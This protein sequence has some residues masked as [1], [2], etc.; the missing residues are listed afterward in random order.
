[1]GTHAFYEQAFLLELKDFYSLLHQH[2]VLG[3]QRDAVRLIE[4]RAG[5][6]VDV[7]VDVLVRQ[8]R[9]AITVEEAVTS[10]QSF[11]AS[12]RGKVG[13]HDLENHGPLQSVFKGICHVVLPIQPEFVRVIKHQDVDMGNEPPTDTPVMWFDFEKCF[14]TKMT[15]SGQQLA[16]TLGRRRIHPDEWTRML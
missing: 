13:D 16:R 6:D 14:A 1:M 12:V 11:V 5:D 9:A 2:H 4:D 15:A 8:L 10:M 7:L 3:I